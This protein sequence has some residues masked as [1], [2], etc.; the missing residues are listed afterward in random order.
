V[1][2]CFS[3]AIDAVQRPPPLGHQRPKLLLVHAR[4]GSACASVSSNACHLQ[5]DGQRYVL[6]KKPPGKLL[7]SA[8]AIEREYRVLSA[9]HQTQVHSIWSSFNRKRYRSDGH[10]AQ[11]HEDC[12][13]PW[14]GRQFAQWAPRPHC[15]AHACLGSA[16]QVPVPRMLCL[17][18]DV[19]VLGEPFYVM[20]FLQ[21]RIHLDPA[22][23][24]LPPEQVNLSGE[25]LFRTCL[26]DSCRTG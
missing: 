6:R 7:A 3:L 24:D 1:P 26:Q 21:G 23:P 13:L 4:A 12:V 9:L 22:L 19:A 17:C 10:E 14:F 15:N 11:D 18:E 2:S 8:H 25:T 20:S 5:A 16:L